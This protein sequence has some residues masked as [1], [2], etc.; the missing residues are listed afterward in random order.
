LKLDN[1]IALVTGASKGIGASIAKA[2]AREGADVLVNYRSSG[3]AAKGVIDEIVDA[4]GRASSAVA[5]ISNPAELDLM[6][7]MIREKF[8]RLDVLVNNAGVADRKIWNARLDEITPDM[9]S[10]VFS[11][12]VIGGFMCTQKSVPLLSR[13][14]S[15]VNISSTQVLVGDTQGLVYACGKAAVLA[16]TKSLARILAPNIR[17]NCM[18][19]GSI[20]T[21]WVDWLDKAT[22]ESYTSSIS[23][24]R[25][26]KPEEVASVALFFASDASSYI[27]GQSIVVDG[28]DV[29]D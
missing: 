6:F 1:K 14:G 10:K 21:S 4:G 11:V 18:I 8:G 9:W 7:A 16:E 20:E 25:F 23:L 13:G 2:L 27:T 24:G 19:L 28:G 3:D 22:I 17:V 26:G 12:D 15:I 5:D 29:M